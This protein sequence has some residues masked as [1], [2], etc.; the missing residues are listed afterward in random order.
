MEPLPKRGPIAR[1]LRAMA[2]S[3]YRYG[4]SARDLLVAAASVGHNPPKFNECLNRLECRWSRSRLWSYPP[5]VGFAMSNYCNQR[6]RFCSLDL[7][8]V[9][10]RVVLPADLFEQMAWLRYV[11]EIWLSGAAG[12]SLVHPEFAR[13]VRAVR[14]TAPKSRLMVCTNGLGLCGENL[15]AT[16]HLDYLNVS[17]NAAAEPTYATLIRD[18]SFHRL[19]ANLESLSERKRPSLAVHLSM[20]LA[21]SA[22]P[23][24]KPMIDLAARLNF[25]AV[26]VYQ[27]FPIPPVE[28]A[29]PLS[30]A[31]NDEP[32]LWHGV[33]QLSDY[34]REKGV[35]YIVAGEQLAP[36]RSLNTAVRYPGASGCCSPWSNGHISIGP[37]GEKAFSI[38]CSGVS[39][40]L[41]IDDAAF[42]DF[43]RVWN[44][45]R[46]QEVRRTVNASDDR[47]NNMCW[48]CRR[49]ERADYGSK[50]QLRELAARKRPSIAFTA[51]DDPIAFPLS[52]V[53]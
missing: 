6:C 48:L 8:Q 33:R 7:K 11:R 44:S 45:P 32:D 35:G 9:T 49:F 2:R 26:E 3:A 28:G 16:D 27:Y 42:V 29:L 24:V 50:G 38:C 4:Q 46:M 52:R 21:R 12:D 18:G 13:I 40:N 20:V 34:A 25:D 31:T 17:A 19:M 43:R 41:A 22:V 53:A 30:E 37:D 23:D 36:C 1:L 51:S 47:Q 10:R 39:L 14:R 5:V 15:E